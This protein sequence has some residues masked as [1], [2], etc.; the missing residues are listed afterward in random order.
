MND[1]KELG[2]LMKKNPVIIVA[3]LTAM[4]VGGILGIIA[5]YHGWLG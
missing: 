5:Y 4:V 1:L 3:T 2:K